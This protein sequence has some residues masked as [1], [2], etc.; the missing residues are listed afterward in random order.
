MVRKNPHLSH[1]PGLRRRGYRE[2][3]CADH[4]FYVHVTRLLLL[5]LA[6]MYDFLRAVHAARRSENL[7]NNCMTHVVAHFDSGDQLV[8]SW[9][10]VFFEYAVLHIPSGC[11]AVTAHNQNMVSSNRCPANER[12]HINIRSRITRVSQTSDRKRVRSLHQSMCRYRAST[13]SLF[14]SWV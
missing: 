2:D 3:A 8:E 9:D 5:V 7:R 4:N 13:P 6:W 11:V 10:C 14:T 1:P 12:K